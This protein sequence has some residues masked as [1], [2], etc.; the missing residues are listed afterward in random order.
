[1][2]RGAVLWGKATQQ[3]VELSDVYFTSSFAV[4]ADEVRALK[5][6]LDR[7]TSSVVVFSDVE[8]S[9]H[10]SG[11]ART[12]ESDTMPRHDLDSIR[13]RCGVRVEDF[14]GYS[15]QQFMDFGPRWGSLRRVE[16]GDGEALVT[17]VMP[18]PF[19]SELASLWLHPA[20]VDVA[21][22]SAQALI[23]GFVAEDTFYVPFSYG[24]LLVRGPI[25]ERAVSHVRLRASS[26]KDFAVFDVAICDERGNEVVSVESF[27]MRRVADRAR[28]T[29]RAP[30]PTVVVDPSATENPISAALRNGMSPAE[31][32]DALDRI[33]AADVAPQVVASSVDLLRWI[34]EVD[35]EATVSDSGDPE[36]VGGPQFERPNISSTFVGPRTPIERELAAMWRDLLGV[37]EVGRDDDFFELGGQSLIA[38]RLFTRM[39]KKYSVDLPLAT[40]FEAPTITQCAAIVARSL[41]I[42]DGAEGDD[43]AP[44]ADG[45]PPA[46]QVPHRSEPAAFR[47]LVTIQKGGDRIPFFCAHGAGGHVLNFRDLA[48]A[49][50]RGQPFYGLQARGVDGVLPPHE[51]IQEMAAAY[52]EEVRAV[53]PHG[54]YMFGGYSGGGLIAYE[55]AQQVIAAGETVAM[56]ALLD[57]VPPGV[58]EMPVT[59][60]MRM[61]R[62]RTEPAQY[63]R[64]IVTRRIADGRRKREFARLDEILARGATVPGELREMHLERSF[65]TAA[66]KYTLEPSAVRVVLLRADDPHLLFDALGDTYG[67]DEIVEGGVEVIRVPGNH[68]TLLLGPNASTLVR[69]LRDTLEVVST[70]SHNSRGEQAPAVRGSVRTTV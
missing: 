59:M 49:M 6:T 50:G 53:Q 34:A 60:K 58:G 7:S 48:A 63:L 28:L 23:A 25:P 19:V 30:S 38:V 56:V 44:A 61:K 4:G 51:T 70:D 13:A 21:T 46:Q 5:V 36:F 27:S 65:G 39:R 8:A 17:T 9:P 62:L 66:D 12:V 52:I 29:L 37:E 67:W 41:G 45:G 1:M 40:L 31:G 16:Y 22:G 33:L 68:D 3:P 26:A 24:R 10:A 15:G 43:A 55:M 57:T 69:T 32:V 64:K 18:A 14:D 42:A 20:V 2:M 35:A 11:V 54:P 47:S